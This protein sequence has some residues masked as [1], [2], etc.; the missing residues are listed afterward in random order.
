MLKGNSCQYKLCWADQLCHLRKQTVHGKRITLCGG[1][2]GQ[3]CRKKNSQGQVRSSTVKMNSVDPG[4]L[5]SVFS[6]FKS[7]ALFHAVHEPHV[8]FQ[9]F[10]FCDCLKIIF[11]IFAK[12]RLFVQNSWLPFEKKRSCIL[13]QKLFFW[14]ISCTDIYS[15]KASVLTRVLTK[16]RDRSVNDEIHRD[17]EFLLVHTYALCD[18][19]GNTHMVW[20]TTF[21]STHAHKVFLSLAKSWVWQALLWNRIQTSFLLILLFP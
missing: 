1:G 20:F 18:Q 21:F 14:D 19:R 2:G 9:A 17:S 8:R 13:L 5:E 4:C 7:S 16:M 10:L 12:K 3:T 6:I 15:P 11:C